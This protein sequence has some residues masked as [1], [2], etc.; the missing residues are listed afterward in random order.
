MSKDYS[1][2]FYDVQGFLNCPDKDVTTTKVI[3]KYLD[4]WSNTGKKMRKDNNFNSTQ[5]S[6]MS[7]DGTG[8]VGPVRY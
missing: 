1:G 8:L 4:N 2:C 3:E 7:H 5:A 6:K